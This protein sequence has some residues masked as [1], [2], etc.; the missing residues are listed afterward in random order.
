MALDVY[1]SPAIVWVDKEGWDHEIDG[2]IKLEMKHHSGALYTEKKCKEKDHVGPIR[3]QNTLGGGESRSLHQTFDFLL[4]TDNCAA[5]LAPWALVSEACEATKD[6]VVIGTKR[7]PTSS[8]TYI[9]RP[10]DIRIKPVKMPSVLNLLQSRY[11]EFLE[12]VR[13]AMQ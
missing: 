6:A 7:L 8:I 3:M 10:E 4:I 5:A 12:D 2:L 9:I 1:G 13:E 11:K